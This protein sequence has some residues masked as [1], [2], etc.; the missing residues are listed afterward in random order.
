MVKLF[1]ERPVFS[2][3]ISIIIV[4]LGVIGIMT[5]PVSQFPEIAPPSVVVS[6]SYNGASAEVV[7]RSVLIPLE[8]QI[9]G[10]EGMTYLSSTASNDGSAAI[11]VYFK[12]GT[13][14]D[15]A[16]VNVQ[17]RVSKAMNLLPADV[18]QSGV[19]T[20]K[21]QTSILMM[22]SV[23]SE[24]NGYDEL[25]LQNF[26]KINI[27]P[28]IQRI[29]G[30]GTASVFGVKDYSMRVWLLPDRMSAYGLDPSD[31]VSVIREQNLEA[32]PGTFGS[33]NEKV[34]EYII[35]YKGKLNRVSDYENIIVKSF[36]NG[37]ILRLKDVARIEFGAFNYGLSAKSMGKD[38]VGMSIYQTSG[39]NAKEIIGEIEKKLEEIS[40]TFPP[41]VKYN[42]PYNTQDFLDASIEHVLHTLLEAFVLV[43]IVVFIFLQDFRSTL[44]PAIAVPV[45]IIG[46]F[47][48][49]NMLGFTINILTLFA[50]VLAIGIVV[51]DAIVVVE[52]VHAKMDEEHLS[53]KPATFRAMNEITGAIISITLI[54]AAVFIPVSFMPGP[55][56]VF[57]KQFSL[58][59]AI[60]IVISAVNA[61]SLSPALCAVFLKHKPKDENQKMS[62]TKK[63]YTA[64]NSAFDSITNRYKK[65]VT[66]LS[67]VKFV[68][69][70]VILLFAAGIIFISKM[71][72]TGFI[73]SED[74]GVVF[75]DVSLPAN[76]TRERT[77]V[78]LNEID[79]IASGMDMITDRLYIAGTGLISGVNGGAYGLMVLKLKP[80]DERKEK[81]QNV[82][83][84]IK[85]LYK[86]TANI[87]DGSIIFFV[88]PTVP[89]F[90]SSDGFELRIKDNTGGPVTDLDKVS[91]EFL[92]ELN[93]KKEIQY[94][95]TSFSTNFP[96][97]I[98]DVDVA[99]CKQTG[100][101]VNSLL[102]TLQG[103]FGGLYASDFNRFGKQY[104]I[105][106]Q[107]E[108]GYRKEPASL[109]G[110]YT[111]NKKGDMVP[112][113][114]LVSL[115]KVYGPESINR[116]NLANSVTVNGKPK[117]G[118]SSGDAIKVVE[119]IAK[120]TL[121]AGFTSEWTGMT[122]EEQSS[123]GQAPLIFG[124]VILF[125]YL[126]LS[127]QYESYIMPF[128]VLLCIPIGIF[129][130][131][132]FIKL[133]DIENNIYFQVGLIMLVG[134][135]AK[136]AILII[137]FAIQRRQQGMSI[138]ES[139]VSGAV[140]R[141]RPI[142]MTS[143]AF[144][145]GLLPLM[146]AKGAGAIG[147]R[148]IGTG[149]IGGMLIG[150]M[151][152]VFFIPVLYIMFQTLDEKISGTPKSNS[153]DIS[154]NKILPE[155]D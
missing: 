139:A 43:F 147:N 4:I 129:G 113:L 69:V 22:I 15:M 14:P 23:Y 114:T 45:A 20:Q 87:R 19:T 56:G 51:D 137:E 81:G 99:K 5:L 28:A 142:L 155:L 105:M 71:V 42:I 37:Q 2:T 21:Q 148:S 82:T 98:L 110:I 84:I 25:F 146:F 150:T 77:E 17:N 101:D 29:T 60:A 10:V 34:F 103:Y 96:Q 48:F 153:S 26:T 67:K 134:L 106:I 31:V 66:S 57:Y 32:A 76:S 62:L 35:K 33:D 55:A 38:G 130:A 46:T 118:F 120:T 40:G 74:V 49:L 115:K 131:F 7:A 86:R 122:R 53:P 94:A 79:K 39:S 143:F 140:A 95:V 136:N 119:E 141:L 107:A 24:D 152:G 54:M 30:V 72:P 125:V 18:I 92:A 1:I 11:T 112:V 75:V 50:M 128:A 126:L 85:E 70:I 117:P 116:Y 123:A 127:A 83:D 121:P 59:L 91:K 93:Q 36:E 9:N 132:L 102:Y 104:R 144:I 154:E 47:F 138:V 61:L 80:W 90:G 52:A 12:L 97:Y 63:F 6:A 27:V 100:V 73:P 68:T 16:A 65:T 135:L 78:V 109:A 41:G 44:I 13:D 64:F 145:F 108:S 124:L 3:V 149:S 8:E 88:P 58:T 133:F 151:V 89:G 111:K